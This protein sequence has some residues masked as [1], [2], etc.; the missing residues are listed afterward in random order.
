MQPPIIPFIDFK[1]LA[2]TIGPYQGAFLDIIRPTQLLVYHAGRPSHARTTQHIS[3]T[4][5]ANDAVQIIRPEL[6]NA[7]PIALDM[8]KE[9]ERRLS[10]VGKHSQAMRHVRGHLNRP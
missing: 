7:P 6:Q 4:F 2:L 1:R 10:L 9:I 3:M 8:V 5:L